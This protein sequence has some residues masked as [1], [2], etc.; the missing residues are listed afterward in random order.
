MVFV[1][2]PLGAGVVGG[3]DAGTVDAEGYLTGIGVQFTT[4]TS[5]LSSC[6]G[7]LKVALHEIGHALGFDDTFGNS[8]SSVMNQFSGGAANDP[9]AICPRT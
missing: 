6:D 3:A 1:Q 2:T 8:G 5:L 7:F 9:S 4:N